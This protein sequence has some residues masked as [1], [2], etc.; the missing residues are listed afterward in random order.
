MNSIPVGSDIVDILKDTANYPVRAI[1]IS[2]VNKGTVKVKINTEIELLPG[3][4]WTYEVLAPPYEY[5][6]KFDVLFAPDDYFIPKGILTV[7]DLL[8]RGNKLQIR[9]IVKIPE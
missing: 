8:T 2:F 6:M 7:P 9:K 3:D 4:G 1:G 5:R